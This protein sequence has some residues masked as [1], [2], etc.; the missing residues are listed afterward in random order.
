MLI[1][2]LHKDRLALFLG[3]SEQIDER[4]IRI[5]W[6]GVISSIKSVRITRTILGVPAIFRAK[7]VRFDVL[8]PSGE[9]V[10]ISSRIQ[11]L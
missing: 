11:A 4:W 6:N 3:L 10:Q 7:K 8:R 5:S 1:L 2:R 9:S